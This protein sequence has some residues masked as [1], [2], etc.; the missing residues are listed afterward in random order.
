MNVLSK[1]FCDPLKEK[2]LRALWPLDPTIT[3]L[4]HG[5]F[6]ACPTA[7]I[8]QQQRLR[9][10]V[11]RNPV[12][13]LHRQLP[14]KLEASRQKIAQFLHVAPKNLVFV[15]NA[16]HGVN[17]VL[18]SIPWQEGDE[19]MVT[20]HGYRACRNALEKV[21][22]QHH[23]TINTVELPFLGI[24]PDLVLQKVRDAVS[25]RT[26]LLMIDQITSTTGLIFP[27]QAIAMD[28]L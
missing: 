14:E 16:T 11:E 7:V 3:F 8:E 28:V 12:Q 5:S 24:T 4:N 10:S 19:V 17:A 6:G 21:A 15:P 23:L 20:N 22:K 25:P 26:R 13:F 27:I 2:N 18:H 9:F 1:T